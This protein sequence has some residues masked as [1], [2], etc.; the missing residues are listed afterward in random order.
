MKFHIT[1]FTPLLLFL[2]CVNTNQDGVTMTFIAERGVN[3]QRISK[4]TFEIDMFEN[5]VGS[6]D[7]YGINT[8][9][10]KERE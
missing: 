1:I 3:I 8:I 2:G 7:L 5:E 6:W 9:T 10:P 4:D